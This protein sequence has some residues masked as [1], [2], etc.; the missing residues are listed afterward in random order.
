[1]AALL[2]GILLGS[3]AA[4]QVSQPIQLF[5][6]PE[7]SRPA[8]EPQPGTG[9]IDGRDGGF[10]VLADGV[11]V[12]E[13]L[14]L[15]SREDGGLGNDLWR[16]SRRQTIALL[17]GEVD[18]LASPTLRTLVL[19]AL[20]TEAETPGA[21]LRPVAAQGPEQNLLIRRGEALLA[22]GEPAYLSSLLTLVGGDAAG[23]P[24]VLGLK[25]Q[26][27]L[28][29]GDYGAACET[30]REGVAREPRNSFWTKAQ[31]ACQAATGE[32]DVALLGLDLLRESGEGDDQGFAALANAALGYGK[33]PAD[34]A[35]TPLNI[36]LVLGSSLAPPQ[37]W[38]EHPDPAVAAMAAR[39]G[40][41]AAERRL[42]LAERAADGG[43]MRPDELIGFYE[44]AAGDGGP[45][46][47]V[48]GAQA[49][50]LLHA[51]ASAQPPGPERADLVRQAMTAARAEG[52]ERGVAR[53]FAPFVADIRPTPVMVGAAPSAA[54]AL[55]LAGL[56]EPAG[57]WI[58]VLQGSAGVNP[59]AREALAE[60]WPL[61]KLAGVELAAGPGDLAA[62]RDSRPAEA[63]SLAL[64]VVTLRGLLYA[65]GESDALSFGELIGSE[66]A[67][68][69][70]GTSTLLALEQAAAGGRLGE[71]VLL[72]AALIGENGV[73]GHPYAT[74][75]AVE[76]LN[77]VGRP[78]EARALALEA[79]V[80]RHL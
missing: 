76:A 27:D 4:A 39:D 61:A 24:A 68:S 35:A 30:A 6:L 72:T 50:A 44:R 67:G 49:R 20:L 21:T 59:A 77:R 62:W 57:A 31:V 46:G 65:L 48:Q 25:A 47:G 71:T 64:Q 28:L 74:A 5:Q 1:M 43:A 18:G 66:P 36:A 52:V 38:Q 79:A 54:R 73:G 42:Q 56:Y 58:D 69:L 55:L 75:K 14:G 33:T 40:D 2:L 8:G 17:L 26:A 11:A 22:L 19:R 80:A 63:E 37:S 9:L 12:P 51:A 13:D 70:T 32:R 78:G 23:S 53:V 29:D 34:P 60:I 16:S 7:P 45:A 15:W 3:G 10:G 41:L